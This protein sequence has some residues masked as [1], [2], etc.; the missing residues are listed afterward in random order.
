MTSAE[1]PLEGRCCG[2]GERL[3]YS[4]KGKK[5]RRQT[6]QLKREG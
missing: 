5:E 4:K 2:A 6:V 3:Y 1:Q